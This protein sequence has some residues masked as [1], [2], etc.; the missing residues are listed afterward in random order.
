[1]VEKYEK[2]TMHWY[3]WWKMCTPKK[4][5]DMG[6]RDMHC[7][8]LAVLAK[9]IWRL[10]IDHN[11]LCA[12]VLSAKYYPSGDILKIGPKKGASFTWQSL[13]A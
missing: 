9:Q 8:N 11:S 12:Q 4:E 5:G 1:V 3:T 13:M 2:K 10:T 7:F 6:F